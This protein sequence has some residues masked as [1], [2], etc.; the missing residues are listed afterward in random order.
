MILTYPY[1]LAMFPLF[2]HVNMQC[3]S[4]IT[5]GYRWRR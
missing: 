1:A 4:F 5:G 3:S 2:Y